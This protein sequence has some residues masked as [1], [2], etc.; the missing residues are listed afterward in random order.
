MKLKIWLM[1]LWLNVTIK[2]WTFL[3]GFE[4]GWEHPE[5]ED[6]CIYRKYRICA[7]LKKMLPEYED[8]L[9]RYK[10]A[11]ILMQKLDNKCFGYAVHL[12]L[13]ARKFYDIRKY[14]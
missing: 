3:Q 4:R 7:K 5:W 8:P 1:S 12:T 9:Y 14:M 2:L 13:H 11:K 10:K 6:Y